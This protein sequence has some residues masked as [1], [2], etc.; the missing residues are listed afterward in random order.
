MMTQLSHQELSLLLFALE[1]AGSATG[2]GSAAEPSCEEA[3]PVVDHL[4]EMFGAQSPE[5]RLINHLNNHLREGM[6]ECGFLEVMDKI[7]AGDPQ[8]LTLDEQRK[9]QQV[10][11]R[12][13]TWSCKIKFEDDERE[14]LGKAFSRFPH[15]AWISMPRTLWRLRKKIRRG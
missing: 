8:T 10:Q 12:L 7:K 6:L 1:G 13:K 9:V 11:D 14:L 3:C 2:A 4:E 15:T 5:K